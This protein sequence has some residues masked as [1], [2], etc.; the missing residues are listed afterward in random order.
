MAAPMKRK[1]KNAIASKE[2]EGAARVRSRPKDRQQCLVQPRAF[3]R[4]GQK[5][6]QTRAARAQTGKNGNRKQWRRQRQR[7]DVSDNGSSSGGGGG[8]SGV[9][10]VRAPTRHGAT[11]CDLGS[12][13]AFAYF[14]ALSAELACCPMVVNEFGHSSK[15][16][17]RVRRQFSNRSA[18]HIV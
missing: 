3:A 16:Q 18:A 11:A 13:P 10:H 9:K 7:T 2:G 17:I 4:H 8:A 5:K 6:K 15:A 14:C 12:M 1:K